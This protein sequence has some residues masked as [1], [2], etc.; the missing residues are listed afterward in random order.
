[1]H[2]IDSTAASQAV[3]S[4]EVAYI[5][6]RIMAESG[7]KSQCI[8]PVLFVEAVIVIVTAPLISLSS[9]AN[10]MVLYVNDL[11]RGHMVVEF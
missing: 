2:G 1:M 9:T 5:R 7:P 11:P 8:L 10:G 6:Y 4:C 3:S